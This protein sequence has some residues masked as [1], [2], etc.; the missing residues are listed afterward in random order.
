MYPD[1]MMESIRMVERTRPKRLEIA[2]KMGKSVFPPMSESER[3]EVLNKYHPDYKEEARRV[4][5]IGMNKGEKITTKVAD[6]LESYSRIDP[7][8]I[9]LSRFDMETDVLVIGAGSAG[10][11]AALEASDAGANVLLAT[12]LRL[13]DSNSMMAQG[14]IQAADQLDDNPA[15]HY[16]DAMGG[17]HFDNKPELVDA[18]VNDGPIAIKWLEDLGVMFDK[19][20]SGSMTVAA[21]GGTSRKRMHSARD[22]T[23]AAI[24]R[25]LRDEVYNRPDKIKYIEYTAIIEL[26]LDDKGQAVGAVAYHLE[27]KQYSLIKARSIIIATGGFGRL[28][29][30]DF[31][32]TN[33]YGATADGL[34]LAYRAGAPLL[35]M[36]SVQ[37]HPTGAVYP[38]QIVG[39]LC[40]E[41]IRGMGAQPV[42]RDGELFV[43]PLE[44]RDVE[45]ASF[46]REST[47]R[48]LGIKTPSGLVGIWLDSP[49][50][51]QLSGEG[52]IEKALPAMLRQFQ[53]FDIDITKYPMLVYPTLHYQNGGIDIN[54][55]AE[56]NIPGLYVAGE[57]S[58][59]VHGRNRLMG[60]S[61]LDIIVFGRRSGRYAAERAASG[62]P[63]GEPTLEHVRRYNKEASALGIDP[64]KVSPVILPDYIPDHVKAKQLTAHYE[65]SLI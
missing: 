57:A 34:V 21:G 45:A 33:H 4:L 53:R 54:E 18:L 10:L 16:L 55:K 40:T 24:C 60:N 13:G 47:D 38:E 1:Y 5:N 14:G 12:K 15:I 43:Y 46:I 39:F 7:D 11:S 26:V 8:R 51:E 19:T 29:V 62:A 50:I 28:H 61:Q 22:Y 2:R 3:A 6:M 9:D 31:E 63:M 52:S 56:T 35:Y 41:K 42:N 32:T 65:G 48:G 44:P 23:G 25:V 36:D 30:M 17:G 27:N 49:L 59:G 20:K 64:K 58:G 37:Y